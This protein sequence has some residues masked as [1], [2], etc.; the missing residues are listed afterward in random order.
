[1]D[2][3]SHCADGMTG[4]D[5]HDPSTSEQRLA[6]TLHRMYRATPSLSL[7][8]RMMAALQAEVS[9]ERQVAL[10]PRRLPVLTCRR[11]ASS[12]AVL[13]V[14]VGGSFGYLRLT[15][16]APVSAQTVL[17][18]AA[19][20]MRLAPGQAAH[21]SYEVTISPSPAQSGET[22]GPMVSNA[23]VWVRASADG[24][25]T[26]SSQTLSVPEVAMPPGQMATPQP[27]AT[28]DTAGQSAPT[29]SGAQLLARYLQI[30]QQVYGYIG[31]S[32]WIVIP[33]SHDQHPGWMIPNA[34]LDGAGVAQELS[35]L[36][37]RSPQQIHLLPEQALGGNEVDVLQ[38]DGWA[39]APGMRTTFYFDSHSSLLRGF[40]AESIDPSYPT[41]SWQVRLTG[42]S[43]MAAV[44]APANVFT[45]NAPADARVDP[46]RFDL[47]GFA[48]TFQ[49]A[50]HSTLAVAQLAHILQAKQQT[51]LAACQSTAPAMTAGDLVG[52]LI[53]PY[54]VTLAGAAAV[55]QITPAQVSAALAAQQQWLATL[56]NTPG[57]GSSLT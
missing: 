44:A 3:L 26:M 6:A 42:Y 50:C 40:D 2:Y 57:G 28:K 36:A 29:G 35:V 18:R 32:N 48:P 25:A 55:V 23:D 22:K 17:S 20:A 52:V 14:L 19:G 4:G 46:P 45:L 54:S 10:R 9:P 11:L 27:A 49:S 21:L 31:G 56:V 51:L 38:V 8:A 39:D 24:T 43:T 16:P 47:A 12:G 13:A 53:A 41:S 34:A 7:D 15:E 30:G 37:Q 33:G 5:G 1:M